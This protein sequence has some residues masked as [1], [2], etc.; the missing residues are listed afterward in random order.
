MWVQT[1]T[2]PTTLVNLDHATKIQRSTSSGKPAVIATIEGTGVP[3]AVV[4]TV[5]A[6]DAI[7]VH[8]ATLMQSNPPLI[9]LSFM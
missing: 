7:L 2:E 3:L 8:V 5:E 1:R 6:A 9:D 4:D